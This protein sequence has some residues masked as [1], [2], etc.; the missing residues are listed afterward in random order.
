MKRYEH[1][2]ILA[3]DQKGTIIHDGTLV[4]DG[5]QIVALGTT[6]D[7]AQAY[8][9]AQRVQLGGKLVLPGLINNHFHLAQT[10]FRGLADD[11]VLEPWLFGRIWPLQ[12]AHDTETFLAGAR[13]AMLEMSKTGTTTFVESMVIHYGLEAL[14]EEVSRT[15]LRARL[16]KV[17]ME[18]MAGSA[19][20]PALTETLEGSLAEARSCRRKV[21]DADRVDIWLGP[22]WTGMYNPGL[23]EAVN[24]A[25][26]TDGF[27]S[28]MHFAESPE[29]VE[30]ILQDGYLTPGDFLQRTGMLERNY[31]L[32]HCPWLGEGDLDRLARGR[33]TVAHCPVSA[34][35]GSMGYADIPGMLERNIAVGI[36][37]DA[38]ACNNTSD[39]LAEIKTAALLHKH[40][41][42]RPDVLPAAQALAM[43]TR[44]G[45]ASI[46]AGDTLGTLAPGKK[47]DFITLALDW[48]APMPEG[49]LPAA[50]VYALCGRDVCDVYVDGNAVVRQ[51]ESLIYDEERI[52]REARQAL[53]TLLKRA[54]L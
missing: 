4:V 3:M 30:R 35:K 8:P 33:A 50:V 54:D 6:A 19:L 2:T 27:A 34:M 36:G 17:V 39:L 43:G 29:D 46:F 40:Q 23:I 31:L 24:D 20:P 21:T 16:A 53:E 9:Q 52:Q 22:R 37:T 7:M 13:L 42:G 1:G 44:I 28:T 49:N 14:F 11:M 51:G 26:D 25:M 15:G 32:I 10:M 47:A 38:P 41:T 12:S 18:P 45:A 48:A 5:G